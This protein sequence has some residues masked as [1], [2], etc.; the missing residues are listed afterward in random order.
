[1]VEKWKKDYE[2]VFSELLKTY[3]KPLTAFS[4]TLSLPNWKHT[5]CK[6][7]H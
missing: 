6:W 7:T 5:L 4:M 2:V 1:M 3:L